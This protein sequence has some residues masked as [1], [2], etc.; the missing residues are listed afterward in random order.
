MMENIKPRSKGEMGF[1]E[2]S[3]KVYKQYL[4][5]DGIISEDGD[6]KKTYYYFEKKEKTPKANQ[7]SWEG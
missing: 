2:V 3:F 1:A 6:I 4:F 5:V 7:G